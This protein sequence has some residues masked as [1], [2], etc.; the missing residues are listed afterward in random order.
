[1][2]KDFMKKL[3][4]DLTGFLPSNLISLKKDFEQHCHT[5]LTQCFTKLDLVTRE[6]FDVQ[7]K[8]LARTRKK[9]EELEELVKSMEKKKHK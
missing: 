1:M 3:A 7:A 2:P 9:M 6:E 5:I 4:E 8:V